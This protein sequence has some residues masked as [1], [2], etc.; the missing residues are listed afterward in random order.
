[1]VN[2]SAA[3]IR[4]GLGCFATE[5]AIYGTG[6]PMGPDNGEERP[7]EVLGTVCSLGLDEGGLDPV[8]GGS[9]RRI[10]PP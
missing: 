5:K 7:V 6:F 8:L 10:L 1:M 9:L 2:G 4:C 3:E